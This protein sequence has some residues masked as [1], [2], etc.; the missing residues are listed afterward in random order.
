MTESFLSSRSIE[1]SY[2]AISLSLKFNELRIIHYTE[3]ENITDLLSVLLVDFERTFDTLSW[4]F[5]QQILE[6][7]KFGASI[8]E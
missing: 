6:F 3:E 1:S 2:F 8:N 7:S 4:N 5:T